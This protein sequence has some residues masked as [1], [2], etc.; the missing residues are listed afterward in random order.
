MIGYAILLIALFITLIVL[1]IYVKLY[2]NEKIDNVQLQQTVDQ[3][4]T[5]A[6]LAETY[7]AKKQ[8]A[9]SNAKVEKESINTGDDTADFNATISM[10]HNESISAS[11][12]QSP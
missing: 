6:S 3:Y 2:K 4:K 12:T 10:L 7:T 8:E 9:E 5:A 11:P 1:V